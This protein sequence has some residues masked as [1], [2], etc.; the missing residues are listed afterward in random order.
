MHSR[1]GLIIG[2]AWSRLGS[3]GNGNYGLVRTCIGAWVKSSSVEFLGCKECNLILIV[4]LSDIF[5]KYWDIS[6]RIVASQ[7]ARFRLFST[8]YSKRQVMEKSSSSQMDEVSV[9]SVGSNSKEKKST[10]L[11]FGWGKFR[12]N[13]L[14]IFNGPKCFLFLLVL[15]TMSQGKVKYLSLYFSPSYTHRLTTTQFCCFKS[16]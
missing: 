13:C 8:A 10:S 9:R 7:H 15:F 4:S 3:D 2:L 6:L 12:P 11:R 16:S 14:Q 5:T 1:L